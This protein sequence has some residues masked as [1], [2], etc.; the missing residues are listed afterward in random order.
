LRL[1]LTLNVDKACI[2]AMAT[3]LADELKRLGP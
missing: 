3:A 1:S 2:E